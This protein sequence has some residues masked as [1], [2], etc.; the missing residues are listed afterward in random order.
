MLSIFPSL[1]IF[2]IFAPF[3]LR[4]A[5]GVYL[6]Y[7]GYAHLREDRERC[8][9]ELSTRFGSFSKT[10]IIIGGI[11]EAVIGLSLIAGF[12]TQVMALLGALYMLKLL[13]FKN[14]YP[15]WIKHER[16]FYLV[17]FAIFVSLLLSGA[18][19]PAIDLPL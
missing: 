5:V 2:G 9:Q 11:F 16:I 17:L 4:F 3:I 1:L 14:S 7:S 10:I 19:V 18:G 13:F 15:I 8:V 6:F 12:L